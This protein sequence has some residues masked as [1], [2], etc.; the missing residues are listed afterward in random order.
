MR[1][2]RSLRHSTRV[3]TKDAFIPGSRPQLANRTFLHQTPHPSLPF[4][5]ARYLGNRTKLP[6]RR[7]Y[8]WRRPS[9]EQ[10]PKYNPT[11]NLN[12]PPGVPSLSL[13]Q[14]LRK[15]SR[16]YGWSAVG[17]YFLLSALDFPFCFIAV[18]SLG[19]ERIG[20]WE[21]AVV[22]WVKRAVPVQIPPAWRKSGRMESVDGPAGQSVEVVEGVAGY[23]HG[24][25]EAEK[26]NK[27][28]SASMWMPSPSSIFRCLICFYEGGLWGY[29]SCG[30]YLAPDAQRGQA[31]FF[32]RTITD[33]S[34]EL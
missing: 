11:P 19:T 25:L 31:S 7:P 26:A 23:D 34:H 13:S 16:E 2:F 30:E 3:F 15:L 6:G 33:V 21:Q 1:S 27:G 22:E 10:P 4:R 9:P 28:D 17:V 5:T 24:V 8:S 18:R 32:Y 20:S 29:A 14:R 12:S